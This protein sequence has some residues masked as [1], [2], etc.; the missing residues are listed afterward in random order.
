MHRLHQNK[1]EKQK[2]WVAREA[3]AMGKLSKKVQNI[4]F[5][6]YLLENKQ[7]DSL[8]EASYLPYRMT[9]VYFL[10]W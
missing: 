5:V 8:T 4:L 2:L 6:W 1:E 3:I 7:M 9:I 10:C